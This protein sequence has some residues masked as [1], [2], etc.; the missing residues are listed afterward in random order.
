MGFASGFVKRYYQLEV[1]MCFEASITGLRQF[2]EAVERDEPIAV[3]LGGVIVPGVGAFSDF[4]PGKEYLTHE[5]GSAGEAA[6]PAAGP[7]S[8]PRPTPA[9][10]AAGATAHAVGHLAESLRHHFGAWRGSGVTEKEVEE[11]VVFYPDVALTTSS[12]RYAYITLR[13]KPFPLLGDG[14]QLVFELPHPRTIKDRDSMRKVGAW[15]RVG[16]LTSPVSVLK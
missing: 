12:S 1:Q 9:E 16:E 14:F 2:G 15:E 13:A 6:G 4:H 5:S 10:A 8:R 11:L 7:W 3:G